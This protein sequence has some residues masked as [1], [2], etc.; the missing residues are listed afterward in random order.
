MWLNKQFTKSF[1]LPVLTSKN[2][3]Q[4]WC[5]LKFSKR[6]N[7]PW[8]RNQ[9]L[10]WLKLKV[11]WIPE[12]IKQ[13][14]SSSFFLTLEEHT[15]HHHIIANSITYED[16]VPTIYMRYWRTALEIMTPRWISLRNTW[17]DR[18][19]CMYDIL[20]GHALSVANNT[21]YGSAYNTL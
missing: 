8:F 13:K 5:K 6:K 10:S 4:S 7:T 19:F 1:F 9:K 16:Q 15:I 18:G 17:I 21:K 12:T 3:I 2:Q 11:K 14:Q 20:D